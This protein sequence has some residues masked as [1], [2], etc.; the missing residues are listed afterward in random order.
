[1]WPRGQQHTHWLGGPGRLTSDLGQPCWLTHTA[2]SCRCPGWRAINHRHG[3]GGRAWGWGPGVSLAWLTSSAL[4]P[5][6]S[7]SHLAPLPQVMGWGRHVSHTLHTPHH[8]LF[9][10]LCIFHAGN[11][12]SACKLM[13]IPI[14]HSQ[15]VRLEWRMIA[16]FFYFSFFFL[17]FLMHEVMTALTSRAVSTG[18]F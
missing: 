18:E 16:V 14:S 4:F 15:T 17:T 10:S 8:P 6:A 1:M 13:A 5:L 12:V 3:G 9:I 11:L 2:C 7:P